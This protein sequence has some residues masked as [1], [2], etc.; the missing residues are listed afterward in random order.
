[1]AGGGSIAAIAGDTDRQFLETIGLAQRCGSDL[2][3][4]NALYSELLPSMID[5][6]SVPG[7]PASSPCVPVEDATVR[8]LHLTDLHLSGGDY[9][10]PLLAL[11]T[12][13]EH[14]LGVPR[15]DSVV[16]TGDFS[17]RCRSEGLG[18]AL[19]FT[20][21]LLDRLQVPVE[22]CIVVPGNHDVDCSRKV[23]SW[24]YP[25]EVDDS[26]LNPGEIVKESRVILL[27][28]KDRYGERFQLFSDSFYE[29]LFGRAYPREWSEQFRVVNLDELGL[30]FVELNSAWE[31]DYFFMKRSGI[32]P[33]ALARAL[34]SALRS[35]FEQ[36]PLRIAVWHH[37]ATGTDKIQDDTFIEHLETCGVKLC[38]H[39]DVHEERLAEV[40]YWTSGERMFV[41]GA[42]SF[43]APSAARPESTPR[44]YN[45]LEINRLDRTVTVHTRQ[46][47][48]ENSP[49]SPWAVWDAGG[50]DTRRGRVTLSWS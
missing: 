12:D 29:P 21:G 32:H 47:P 1:L 4:R 17:D 23:Y 37:A 9:E 45:L 3:P 36:E 48:R 27:R 10:A 28:E 40:G 15:V 13:L 43:G 30:Q 35:E 11:L 31:I 26:T 46:K 38:L 5:R 25:H 39:G 2:V 18:C 44:F 33:T 7:S 24:H 8:V 14:E 22:R 16:I 49:W 6:N 19:R 50:G 20:R 41:V 42:G 34:D